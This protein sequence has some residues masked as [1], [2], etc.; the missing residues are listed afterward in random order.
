MLHA[1]RKDHPLIDLRLFRNRNLT[2]SVVTMS[3]FII[4]F[5]GAMLL[6]PSYFLQVRGEGT[7]DAGLLLAP[8]GLGAMLTMPIAG[9]AGRQDR[10]RQAGA[11][12]HR[13]DRRRPGRVHPGHRRHVVL[14]LLGGLFVMGMGMGCTMMPIMSAAL[15]TLTDQRSPAARR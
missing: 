10:A 3:L 12:R 15:A 8:Q 6:L 7:L 11:R 1:L 5:M 2:I 4:A 13:A 14:L 9:P